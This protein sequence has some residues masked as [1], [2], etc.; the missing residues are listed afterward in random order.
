MSDI[1]DAIKVGIAA[2]RLQFS[3]QRCINTTT[4]NQHLILIVNCFINRIYICG[5]S[6]GA[7]LAAMVLSTSVSSG[8]RSKLAGHACTRNL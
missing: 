3:K 6:A 8:C 1:V 4:N 7:H 2:V 5:H